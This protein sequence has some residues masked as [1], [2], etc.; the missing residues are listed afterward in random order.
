MTQER[1]GP[2]VGR[3]RGPLWHS[4]LMSLPPGRLDLTRLGG[5]ELRDAAAEDSGVKA[6][7]AGLGHVAGNC[8]QPGKL[9]VTLGDK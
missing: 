5:P 1:G 2:G 8:G 7:P 3:P 6:P 4:A 9:G